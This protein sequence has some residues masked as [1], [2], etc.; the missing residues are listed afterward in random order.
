MRRVLVI[1]PP[2]SGNSTFARR[3]SGLTGLPCVHLNKE[4]W[5]P[6]WVEPDR[7]W[8]R[9]RVVHLVSQDTWIIEGNFDGTLDLR[10]PRADTLFWFRS[11]R[12][13]SMW[14]V[15]WRVAG[16][17]GQVRPDMAPGCPER[18][19]FGFILY[20][21]RLPGKQGLR[22]TEAVDRHGPHLAPVVITSD[23]RSQNILAALEQGSRIDA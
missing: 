19:D 8:W 21:W 17:Y 23:A 22:A 15:A 1:G 3:L 18:V 5:Q 13:R 4:Y 7:A 20:I 2:G 14:R 10:L 6:G 12:V 11:C 9:D 16:S